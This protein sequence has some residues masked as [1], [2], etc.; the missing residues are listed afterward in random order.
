MGYHPF[1]AFREKNRHRKWTVTVSA[2]AFFCDDDGQVG[3]RT[4]TKK[5][6]TRTGWARH[7][8]TRTAPRLSY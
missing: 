6:E 8:P 7:D 3:V 5:R 4:T 2:T 1:E